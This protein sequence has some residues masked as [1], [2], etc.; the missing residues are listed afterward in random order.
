GVVQESEQGTPQGGP[1]SPLLANIYLHALDE[2]LAE[3]GLAFCRYADD[4][5]IYVGSE[6]AAERVLEQVSQWIGTELRLEV[7][8]QKS[9]VGRPWERQFLG[10][11]VNVAGKIEAAP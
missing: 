4:C 6:R 2:E 3:R 11:R 7:N 9:G 8:A 5:N 10:F 1:L